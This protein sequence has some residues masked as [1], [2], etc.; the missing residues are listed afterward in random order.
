MKKFTFVFMAL[1]MIF[2]AADIASAD[3]NDGLVAYYPFDGNT[4][5]ESGNDNHG[6]KNE[7]TE[8][9]EGKYGQAGNF[10]NASE[11]VVVQNSSE[12]SLTEWSLS[13]WIYRVG[14][15]DGYIV[16]TSNATDRY[17]YALAVSGNCIRGQYET[18]PSD[19]DHVISACNIQQN[20]WVHAISTRSSSGEHKIYIN[21]I[22]TDSKVWNDTPAQDDHEILLCKGSVGYIDEVRIYNRALS[23]SEIKLLSVADDYPTAFS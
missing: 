18:A 21:G 4:N 23:E 15:M 12:L 7:Q 13:A 8:Y 5:D 6:T 17:N 1:M 22:L 11:S 16:T 19:Y 14:S 9:L 2:V 10:A 3:L 20:E